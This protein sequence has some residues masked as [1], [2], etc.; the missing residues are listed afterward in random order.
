MRV[1]LPTDFSENAW[2]A[3]K[4]AI[5]LFENTTCT[6]YVMHAHQVS[7]SALISTINK[8]RDTRLHE[9]TQDEVGFKLHKLVGQL[10][11]INK[12]CEPQL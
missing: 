11:K 2:H 3:I 6:F 4:Y 10:T 8:E 9:I 7:P 5:Y 1:L 12:K